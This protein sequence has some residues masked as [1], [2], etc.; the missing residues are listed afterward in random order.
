VE[1]R[2]DPFDL[3]TVWRFEDGRSVETLTP[4][5]I[6]NQIALAIPEERRRTAPQ[7]SEAAG[8][9]FTALRERHAKLR[10][11]DMRIRYDRLGEEQHT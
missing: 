4:Y 10:N 8:A 11:T 5:H 9:Y 7:I 1:I 6:S 3:R 2:Y